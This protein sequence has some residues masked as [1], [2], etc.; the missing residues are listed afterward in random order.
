MRLDVVSS[1]RH[2]MTS[3]AV[4]WIRLL[5]R[6]HRLRLVRNSSSRTRTHQQKILLSY[7][8]ICWHW[9]TTSCIGILIAHLHGLPNL[10]ATFQVRLEDSSYR[11]SGPV[12]KYLD[13]MAH[14]YKSFEFLANVV[15][16]NTSLLLGPLGGRYAFSI[17]IILVVLLRLLARRLWIITM[18][19]YII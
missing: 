12:Y 11:C 4:P 19:G 6:C 17:S 16:R 3:R 10:L 13:R 14:N 9:K 7:N 15:S 5:S 2:S 1:P 8:K 18:P